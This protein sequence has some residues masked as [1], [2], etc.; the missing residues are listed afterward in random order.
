[1]PVAVGR[2]RDVGDNGM[3]MR[4]GVERAARVML[5]QRAHQIAGCD[6]ALAA[7]DFDAGFGG[8]AFAPGQRVL[9]RCPIGLDDAP[10]PADKRDQRP[11][12]GQ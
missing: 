9:D 4:L 6:D 8:I 7:F 3:K 11:A 2:A 10:V 12:F 1:M 5:E